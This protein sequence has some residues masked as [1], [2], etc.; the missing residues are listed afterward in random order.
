MGIIPTTPSSFTQSTNDFGAE[1]SIEQ[2]GQM[3]KLE[4]IL[5]MGQA[6]NFIEEV[7]VNVKLGQILNIEV[8]LNPPLDQ[9]L[10]LLRSGSLGLGFTAKR[11]STS[12]TIGTDATTAAPPGG[13]SIFVNKLAVRLHYAG[14]KSKWF[15]GLLLQPDISIT[16]EG[17]SITLKAIGM[18]FEASKTFPTKSWTGQE[19]SAS[20]IKEL[21]GDQVHI[22]YKQHA[23]AIFSQ[24]YG[25]PINSTKNNMEL[26][27]DIIQEQNCFMF[28]SGSNG[29]NIQ[30]ITISTINEMRVAPTV[31]ATFVAYRQIN[32]SLR[33]F[34][35]T[36]FSAPIQNL[37]IPSGAWG[38]VKVTTMASSDKVVND[39]VNTPTDTYAAERSGKVSSPDG[40]IGGG[41]SQGQTTQSGDAAGISRSA[42]TGKIVPVPARN[43]ADQGLNLMKGWVHDATD[44]VFTY[45]VTGM[46]VVDLLPGS[47]VQILISDIH[48]LSGVFDCSE[49][50][51]VMGTGGV[52]TKMTLIRT[53][54]LLAAA[55][56][57][58][59][60]VKAKSSQLF[61]TTTQSSTTAGVI[62]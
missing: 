22:V 15:K 7:K 55:S 46:G 13:T 9:A 47:M 59:E 16:P 14:L 30:N 56:A 32:P 18:L 53:G 61:G 8:S 60:K 36:A 2:N 12:T 27:K 38:G 31:N 49:V 1:L 48:E 24:P 4:S 34:P 51:H 5:G 33:Q 62:Q 58:V 28:M 21:L 52:E 26:A 25:K 50:E 10:K 43:L 44:S 17:V 35:L 3:T 19:T 42:A 23:D 29:T 11:P 6:V 20:I 45:D 41:A 54:G 39:Q 40:S 37:L 57:G